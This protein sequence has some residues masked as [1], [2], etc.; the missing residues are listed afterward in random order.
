MK[1]KFRTH[2]ST[3]SR[4]NAVGPTKNTGT[5]LVRKKVRIS[6]MLRRCLR[7]RA[8][9]RGPVLSARA[10][11]VAWFD[12]TFVTALAAVFL[13]AAR[14]F[15]AVRAVAFLATGVFAAGS[16]PVL[17]LAMSLPFCCGAARLVVWGRQE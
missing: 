15:G 6:D 10:R 11:F 2:R 17:R 8:G 9:S 5:S 4:L 12:P 16:T 7:G 13:A 3:P 14:F 1:E